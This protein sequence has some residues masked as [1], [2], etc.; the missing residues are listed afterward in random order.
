MTKRIIKNNA[1]AEKCDEPDDD[2]TDSKNVQSAE[3]TIT[4][5]ASEVEIVLKACTKYRNLL[6]TYIASR[7]EEIRMVDKTIEKFLKVSE[8]ILLCNKKN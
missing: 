8:R 1:S 5:N 3:M 2:D 4:L 7:Q 6:P